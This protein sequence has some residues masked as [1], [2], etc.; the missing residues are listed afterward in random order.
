M[1]T[2]DRAKQFIPFNALKGLQEALEAKERLPIPRADLSEEHLMELDAI[3]RRVR[4]GDMLQ[5]ICYHN[6]H[7][8]KITGRA[9]KIS[10]PGR[11]IRITERSIS[12]SDIYDMRFI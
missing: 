9:E 12:F 5:L 1:V 6:G 10:L 2:A 8:E 11:Y 7:Y 3:V 4:E